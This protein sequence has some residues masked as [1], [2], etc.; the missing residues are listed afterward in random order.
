MD[1]NINPE[2]KSYQ[3]SAVAILDIVEKDISQIQPVEKSLDGDKVSL[4]NRQLAEYE[5]VDN[6]KDDSTE[7]SIVL[8]PE[9]EKTE[10]NIAV[11]QEKMEAMGSNLKFSLKADSTTDDIVVQVTDRQS[12]EVVR[13]IPAEEVLEIRAKLDDLVGLLFDQEA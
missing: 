2:V 13:Q 10:E 9:A 4:K 6:E 1:V 7:S 12:G 8:S 11:I 3:G 5:E